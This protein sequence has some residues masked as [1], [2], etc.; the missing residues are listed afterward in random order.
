MRISAVA[1]ISILV[2]S[3]V[4][5]NASEHSTEPGAREG[6][7]HGEN[8][9]KLADW[10]MLMHVSL[11]VLTFVFG[12][13][14]SK[15]EFKYLG[16]AGV[17]LIIGSL[18]GIILRA[19]KGI[20]LFQDMVKFNE[21]IFFLVLLPPIIFEAGYNMKRRFFFRNIGAIC[22]FAFLGTFISTFVVGFLVWMVGQAGM[23]VEFGLL[24]SL[25]FGALISATDPVTVLAVFSKLNADMDLFSFVFGESVLNDAVA[26]VLYVT[27][28]SFK[29]EPFTAESV[30]F[31]VFQFIEIFCVSFLIGVGYAMLLA[32]WCKKNPVGHDDEDLEHVQS[33]MV[34]I[35]PY[36]AYLTAESTYQSGI[37]TIL[38]CGIGMAVFVRP[39]ISQHSR[40][41][42]SQL[43]KALA[44]I[45]E[46]YVFVYLGLSL[47]TIEQVWDTAVMSVYA[48]VI[49]LFARLCN[50]Y[51]NSYIL[52][53]FAGC[54]ID[55]KKQFTM[56]F[57]GL[58]GAIAFV[59]A[60]KAKEDFKDEHGDTILTS[61]ILIIFFTVFAMG[62]YIW[63]LLERFD[64]RVPP[65]VGRHNPY[66]NAI[67][68]LQLANQ[69]IEG[70]E[71]FVDQ[72]ID[73][74]RQH[75]SDLETDMETLS[76]IKTG[77]SSRAERDELLVRLRELC[78]DFDD[79]DDS[80]WLGEV[81]GCIRPLCSTVVLRVKRVVTIMVEEEGDQSPMVPMQVMT[82]RKVE[83]HE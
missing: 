72:A 34:C 28:G 49:C 1:T 22:M 4:I 35:T 38:F 47:F 16:E 83:Q 79:E 44:H 78:H 56:W 54:A 6:E 2:L 68:V 24:E 59:L 55:S 26:I 70:H 37:V 71:D 12:F 48:M 73:D 46:T 45:F 61:T 29:T 18:A 9:E 17:G 39:N 33:A 43:A 14:L 77:E 27:L 74:L 58:R 5:I 42:S 57:A 23:A 11:L 31:G 66:H 75:K 40:D 80:T 81:A 32:Y 60:L 36:L 7:E 8:E 52:N 69:K 21:H 25:V 62:G 10:A 51:P 53:N 67:H 50:I 30:G 65:E 64:L 20:H 82:D 15:M 3:G 41:F 13:V 63:P 76:L 19:S